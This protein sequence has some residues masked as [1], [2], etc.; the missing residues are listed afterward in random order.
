MVKYIFHNARSWIVSYFISYHRNQYIGTC[1]G[2]WKC[3]N[4]HC[5]HL[6]QDGKINRCQFTIYKLQFTIKICIEAAQRGKCDSWKIREFPTDKEYNM[7][8]MKYYGTQTKCFPLKPKPE[9]RLSK[10]INLTN[11]KAGFVKIIKEGAKFHQIELK[12]AV[13]RY[14]NLK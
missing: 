2:S 9:K 12:V 11:Q 7:A 4:A 14:T 5:P 3:Y 8:T 10:K 1:K 13:F 6:T